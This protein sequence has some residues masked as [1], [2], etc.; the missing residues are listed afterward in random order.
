MT[1]KA[2]I[3][4]LDGTLLD[5]LADLCNSMNRVLK[6]SGLPVH[7][8]DSYRYFV[9]DGSARL[10]ERAL[11][12]EYRSPDT[13]SRFLQSFKDDYSRNWDVDTTP[14]P[15]IPELLDELTARGVPM[16][17]NTNKPHE[18]ALTCVQRLL[19]DRR[20]VDIIGQQAHLPL[21]PDADGA[22][23]IAR[24]MELAPEKIA[25]VGDSGV[26]MQTAV[27]AGMLPVGALWGFRTR[28]ELLDNGAEKLISR[29]GDLLALLDDR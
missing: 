19:P 28:Q 9:G 1:V 4:D 8:L 14:F 5:T 22:L 27:N 26:D 10:V 18:F 13:V 29:P 20:F 7:P 21:K 24:R 12:E 2:V 25:F 16:A 11:P 3:F 6:H 23:E 15:G 17:I